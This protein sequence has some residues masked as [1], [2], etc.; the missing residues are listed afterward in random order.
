MNLSLLLGIPVFLGSI[1][2]GLFL[3]VRPLHT[4]EL[5][6]QFYLRINW[7]M[8]PVNLSLEIRNTRIMGFIVLG[9]AVGL[10][11]YALINGGK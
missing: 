9:A 7:R 5:Q 2:L 1:I 3:I 4:I 11:L 10:G 8:E 6:K